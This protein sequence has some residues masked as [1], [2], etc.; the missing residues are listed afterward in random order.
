MK[1]KRKNSDIL[2]LKRPELKNLDDK[3]I[4][5]RIA[6]AS[7]DPLRFSVMYPTA[8]HKQQFL[9]EA[10]NKSSKIKH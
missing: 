9:F 6:V 2:L 1:R 5:Q 8:L 7:L 4:P 10:H 3:Q